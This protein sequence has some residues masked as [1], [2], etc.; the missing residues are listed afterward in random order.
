[1]ALGQL[2]MACYQNLLGI[3]P[4]FFDFKLHC[5][6]VCSC[7]PSWDLRP[8]EV[9]MNIVDQNGWASVLLLSTMHDACMH[10]PPSRQ[11]PLSLNGLIRAWRAAR[12][13]NDTKGNERR[14][15]FAPFGRPLVRPV[16]LFYPST[17]PNWAATT[18]LS[19]QLPRSYSESCLLG[20][21]SWGLFLC[22]TDIL[23]R[24][25]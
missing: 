11:F 12:P 5:V 16:R 1:M 24:G 25:K 21:Q 7:P 13:T 6:Q 23:L 9:H 15:Q 20:S 14:N 10:R 18:R 2:K 17:L 22:L 4:N 19:Q 8:N 3:F